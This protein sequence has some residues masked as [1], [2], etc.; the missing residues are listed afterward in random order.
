MW[1]SRSC[2]IFTSLSTEMLS[3]SSR[4][5]SLWSTMVTIIIIILIM[6]IAFITISNIIVVIF[7]FVTLFLLS[8]YYRQYFSSD[9]ASRIPAND[10]NTIVI[11]TIFLLILYHLWQTFSTFIKN[12]MPKTM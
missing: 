12:S 8:S 3:R 7:S 5:I 6:T 10:T 9:S 11:I 4:H 2:D 1:S